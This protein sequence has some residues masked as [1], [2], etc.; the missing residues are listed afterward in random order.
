MPPWSE[1]AGAAASSGKCTPRAKCSSD[2]RQ[3]K[4][5][6]EIAEGDTARGR[7]RRPAR[8]TF[9]GSEKSFSEPALQRDVICRAAAPSD[10]Y[11]LLA[12]Q[13]CPCGRIN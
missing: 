9:L 10:G 4:R 12:D 5:Q 8:K 3:T 1:R 7:L 2:Y 6:R 11:G 13:A